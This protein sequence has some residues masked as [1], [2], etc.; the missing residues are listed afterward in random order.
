MTRFP[1]GNLTASNRVVSLAASG[2]IR[3]PSGPRPPG[4]GASKPRR[5][6][7]TGPSGDFGISAAVGYEDSAGTIDVADRSVLAV[8][9]GRKAGDSAVIQPALDV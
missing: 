9:I 5:R 4:P 8:G 3:S 7:P 6:C 2:V 1:D